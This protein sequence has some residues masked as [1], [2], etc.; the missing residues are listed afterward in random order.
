MQIENILEVLYG[1]R[2]DYKGTQIMRELLENND[3]FRK[4]II[5]GIKT[6]NINMWPEELWKKLDNQNFREKYELVSAAFKA[7]H[8]LGRCLVYSEYVSY[9][10]PLGCLITSG[11]VDYLKG[12]FNSPEGKHTWIEYENVIYDTTFMICINKKYLGKLGYKEIYKT[13]PNKNPMY[14]SGK[15]FANDTFLSSSKKTR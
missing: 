14:S 13:D 5:E 3:S 6:S 15:D 7:G 1:D 9:S 10:M 2:K 4:I 11:T 12:T 8:N